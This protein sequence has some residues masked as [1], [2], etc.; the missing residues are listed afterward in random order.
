M[1][2]VAAQLR[3]VLDALRAKNEPYKT[4]THRC[5]LCSFRSDSLL[6]LAQHKHMPHNDGRKF[7]CALCP[8]FDT[9]ER[10][11][12][13]HYL[14]KHNIIAT[15]E[16]H[17]PR[18]PCPCCDMDFQ[19]KGQRDMHLKSCKRNYVRDRLAPTADDV[20]TVSRWLWEKPPEPLVN[21]PFA[22]QAP[23]TARPGQLPYSHG[24]RLMS[25]APAGPG[26]STQRM[27]VPAG[28]T[29]GPRFLSNSRLLAPFQQHQQPQSAQQ[30]QQNAINAA[31]QQQ[32]IQQLLVQRQQ[33]SLGSPQFPPITGIRAVGNALTPRMPVRPPN[34]PI[35]PR[36]ATHAKTLAEALAVHPVDR[37]NRPIPAALYAQHQVRQPLVVE[38]LCEICD[39]GVQ[40]REK[41]LAHLQ[42]FHK[43]MQRKTAAD[44]AQG[45]PLACSRCRD[46][47]WTYEGL[48]RHLVMGHGLV[49]SDLL[50]KA[51]KKEDG[52]RC[53]LCAKQYAFN[54][55]QHL[56]TDHQ[57]KLCSAEIMY[58]CDVC[59]FKCT[60]YT[61]LE[62]H[63]NVVHPHPLAAQS[64]AP[65]NQTPLPP[66]PAARQEVLKQPEP[67]KRV[68]P[69]GQ[70]Q[71]FQSALAA[72][73]QLKRPMTT[74]AM[75]ATALMGAADSLP[76][77][78]AEPA[79]KRP[80]K[81]KVKYTC[82]PCDLRFEQYSEV[83]AHWQRS[84]LKKA[85]V[86]LCRIDCC[87]VHREEALTKYDCKFVFPEPS[88]P[89]DDVINS[90]ITLD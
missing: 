78:D 60:G 64:S 1:L 6:V 72:A 44:M 81:P 31:A 63:L 2:Q 50:A 30:Q 15:E 17:G 58:S 88:G 11:I 74:A 54:M 45:A 80:T 84:H 47:F 77:T 85:V 69:T 14:K 46:R 40:D 59:S 79:A 56:V 27:V 70:H 20:A 28:G 12:R 21:H 43:Q 68:A 42:L 73:N 65:V 29:T 57:L 24:L 82:T 71:P 66:P 5:H 8:D 19:Y 38:Q 33:N 32:R 76:P 36:P 37:Q 49:T 86:Q 75:P 52:G 83:I 7:L 41:Y 16:D 9:S 4:K 34:K 67:Q 26:V 10:R 55:L 51:Q 18:A 13:K 23:P 48:E 39:Q 89:S 3:P 61:A 22:V 90:V 53:K 87:P 35:E 62:E 25:L